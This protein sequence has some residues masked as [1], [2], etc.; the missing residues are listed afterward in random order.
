EDLLPVRAVWLTGLALGRLSGGDVLVLA[1]T[2]DRVLE[3]LYQHGLTAEHDLPSFL[4][5]TGDRFND[6]FRAFRHWLLALPDR[7]YAW[8]KRVHTQLKSDTHNLQDIQAYANLML[9]FGF[10]RLGESEQA[11]VL[12]ERA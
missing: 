5:F 6:R 12:H 8:L 7:V 11:R 10:A 4:R 3:R 2:R 1:H 9:A